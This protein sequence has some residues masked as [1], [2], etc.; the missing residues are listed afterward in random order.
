MPFVVAVVIHLFSKLASVDW[1][2]FIRRVVFWLVAVSFHVCSLFFSLKK[3]GCKGFLFG[4]RFLAWLVVGRH[5]KHSLRMS[6][7]MFQPFG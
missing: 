3:K 5:R 6:F 7:Q 2:F 1:I 4:R